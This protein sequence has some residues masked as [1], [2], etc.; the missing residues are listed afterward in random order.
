MNYFSLTRS[1]NLYRL[2]QVT[3]ITFA[4][5]ALIV[6]TLPVAANTQ[7]D[8]QTAQGLLNIDLGATTANVTFFGA[9]ASDHLS[10]NGEPATVG[11]FPRAHAIVTGDF[12]RDGVADVAI[13]APDTDFT[14]AGQSA[15]TNAGAVYILFGKASF[16]AGTII[17]TNLAA[18]SQPD[19]KIFG[20]VS[21]DNLGFALAAGD[22]NG[23]GG[24]DLIMG[25]PGF[26][27]S[28]GNPATAQPEAGAVHILFGTTSLTPKLIDLATANSTNVVIFGEHA[29]DRFGSAIAASDVTGGSP[30][31]AD[32]L[33][34]APAS[35]GP[36]PVAA[37]RPLGG[38]AFL[39]NGGDLLS[40]AG[41]TIKTIDLGAAATPAAVR[42]YGNT[43]SQ[44]G[45]SVAIGDINS[46]A[47]ADIIVG[48]PKANRPNT[49]GDIAETGA[50]FAIFGGTNLNP[51]AQST[52]KVFDINTTGQSVSIYGESSGDHLGASVAT[53]SVRVSGVTDLIMGAPEADGPGEGRNNAGE[54]YVLAGSTGLNTPNDPPAP[55]TPIQ[56]RI[57]V[58][59]GSV[60]LTVYGAGSGD[61]F[62][63]TVAT[64]IFNTTGNTDAF[65]DVLA[66][67][68]GF[69]TSKGAVY[70]L[71]G[72]ATLTP[73]AARDLAIGQDDFRVNGQANGDEL[74]WAIAA[75]DIDSNTGGDLIMGAPE[76]DVTISEANTRADAGK[77]YVL[78]AAGNVIPPVN[79]NP[80]VK[81]NSPNTAV[82]INGGST[83]NITWDA[84]DANGDGTIQRFSIELSIDGGTTFNTI[85]ASNVAGN[86]RTF[87]WL[88][89]TGLNTQTARIRVTAF[90]DAGG[91]GQD[92]SDT[93][94][95]I[96]DAGVGVTITAPVGGVTLF[97]GT[98]FNITWDVPVALRPQL[99]GFDVFFASDGTNFVPI[100]AVDPTNPAL[101][102]TVFTLAWTVPNI[103]TTTA[104]ILVRATSITNAISISTSGAFTI[105]ERGP[106]V[107]LTGGNIFFNSSG[108]KLNFRI[109]TINGIEVRFEDGVKLEI[110]NDAAGTTFFEV[111]KTKKKSSGNKLQS[112]GKVNDQKVGDFFPDGA[113]RLVRI[114]NPT[115][116][117]TLL[118]LKR[119]GN[120]LVEDTLP[121][122]IQ[123]FRIPE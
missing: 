14:P 99:K 24:T 49:G 118:R 42:I 9:A 87:P 41:A 75:G 103:C 50:V 25:A 59:L 20:A 30:A 108:T 45:S 101:G 111:L 2:V 36:A 116:G 120:V 61:R 105:A 72:G 95:T 51:P 28:T 48:A 57:D 67:A 64:G 66:G 4:V 7:S 107:D 26:D 22:V 91:T 115:C 46:V 40:N 121:V 112:K 5:F 11:T 23:D 74:G 8:T 106:T 73:F 19:V 52:T 76:A 15:R 43:G 34:G 93:N 84:S 18:T 85:I 69:S 89:P 32:L 114:T 123:N 47:P 83:F 3:T 16:V 110:S 55:G 113:T 17:D 104:K 77:V 6:A 94:F 31:V 70:A 88:V 54:V 117:V 35:A 92:S 109:T 100:T 38:A 39:L 10:G 97:Q 102:P 65:A 56:R 79:Q 1:G 12:N 86:L 119:V 29:G 96:S 37:A 21:E 60:N 71:F 90:D 62:G 80:T 81:V 63:S 68:P 13:G 44:L 58:S 78:L 122:E 53:G 33:V 98:T 82:V 27:P